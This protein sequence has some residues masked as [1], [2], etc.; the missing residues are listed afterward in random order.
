MVNKEAVQTFSK[1]DKISREGRTLGYHT[2]K[3]S[4]NGNTSGK[5]MIEQWVL[6]YLP[7]GK[8]GFASKVPLAEIAR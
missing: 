3:S 6:P 4:P 2:L 7:V 1:K 5:D 8:R